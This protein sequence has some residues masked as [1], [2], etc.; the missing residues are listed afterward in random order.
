MLTCY[1]KSDLCAM[2]L[3]NIQTI[4]RFSSQFY[5]S[6]KLMLAAFRERQQVMNSLVAPFLFC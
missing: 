5:F 6:F 2:I 3:C 1:K 4:V